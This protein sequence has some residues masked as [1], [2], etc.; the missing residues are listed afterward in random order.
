MNR[1]EWK[2]LSRS[3]RTI[4]RE[5]PTHGQILEVEANGKPYRI[6]ARPGHTIRI[7]ASR[8]PDRPTAQ[9]VARELRDAADERADAKSAWRRTSAKRAARMS[10]QMAREWRRPGWRDEVRAAA[11]RDYFYPRNMIEGSN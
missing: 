3:I 2:A 11:R 7:L 8:I 4:R 1:T 5:K 6:I 9:L 10:L